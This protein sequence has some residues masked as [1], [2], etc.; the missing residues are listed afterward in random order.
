GGL[1]LSG[2]KLTLDPFLLTFGETKLG[3]DLVYEPAAEG[4][5]AHVRTRLNGN[6][7]DLALLMPITQK[8]MA[9]KNMLDVDAS[10]DVMSPRISNQTA[11]RLQAA[12]SRRADSLVLDRMAVEDMGGLNLTA[13]GEIASYTEKLKG[14]VEFA[15]DASSPA[16]LNALANS[17]ADAETAA[18]IR[19]ITA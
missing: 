5:P 9:Q 1:L 7:V 6:A 8:L 4:K 3:G 2:E 11:R 18:Y 15:A 14:R 10:L 16:G 12:F 13:H 17:F 19:R